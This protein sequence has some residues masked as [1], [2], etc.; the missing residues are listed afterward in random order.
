MASLVPSN[1]TFLTS[2]LEWT[3]VKLKDSTIAQGT[4]KSIEDGNL[5]IY[6]EED[7]S[8]VTENI[9]KVE[10]VLFYNKSDYLNRID[11]NLAQLILDKL[12]NIS[13]FISVDGIIKNISPEQKPAVM[14]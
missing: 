1:P 9:R 14:F 5:V 8:T 3:R 13:Q 2:E 7:D 6:S 4:I 11:S 10:C 12:T